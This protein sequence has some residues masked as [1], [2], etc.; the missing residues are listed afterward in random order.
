[1]EAFVVSRLLAGLAFVAATV[2]AQGPA[3]AQAELISA[4]AQ[5]GA[6]A[7]PPIGWHLFCREREGR[8]DCAVPA[9]RPLDAE[10]D[11][12]RWREILAINAKVNREIE[13]MTDAEHWG[14]PEKWSYP[15]D[16]K[17]DCEDYVLE[18]RR[19]LIAAGIPRQ[20]LLITVVR[21]RKGDGHA[22]LMIRTDR[23]DFILDNQEPRVR[24]WTET[25]Y[26][27]IKRQ[28]QEDPNRWVSLGNVDTSVVTATSR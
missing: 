19:R 22:V 2:A 24:L 10:L 4:Y 8:A 25:G 15:T 12:R 3:I 21:D 17:G 6:E 20:A 5:H 7:S 16:G 28:S 26:R 27:F 18:K 11:E 23:G 14:V 9:L 1:M 13:P